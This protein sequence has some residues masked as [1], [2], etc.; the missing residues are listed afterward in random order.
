MLELESVKTSV[1]SFHSTNNLR[2]V[3]ANQKVK[4]DKFYDAG[5]IAENYY[6]IISITKKLFFAIRE[7]NNRVFSLIHNWV[8]GAL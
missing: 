6:A 4:V 3:R 5:V 8:L 1:L 2:S 7:T